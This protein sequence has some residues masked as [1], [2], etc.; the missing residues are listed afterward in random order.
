MTQE[1]RDKLKE[2]FRKEV[3]SGNLHK[4]VLGG[5]QKFLEE[6]VEKLEEEVDAR[7]VH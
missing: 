5:L 7:R 1:Q 2:I 4:T 3:E 6:R